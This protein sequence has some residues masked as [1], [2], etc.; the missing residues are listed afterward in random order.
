LWVL[1]IKRK[2][3]GGLYPSPN[4]KEKFMAPNFLSKFKIIRYLSDNIWPTKKIT[5]KQKLILA[6]LIKI[7]KKKIS[8]FGQKLQAKRALSVLYGN[9]SFKQYKTIKEKARALE[10]KISNNFI[11]LLEKRLDSV[12]YR[13]NICSTFQ[14]SKQLILHKKVFVNNRLIN[15]PSYSLEPGDVIAIAINNTQMFKSISI[16]SKKNFDEKKV[17]Q[18]KPLHLE[19]NYKTLHAIFLYPPQKLL[20]SYQLNINLLTQ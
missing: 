15:I 4:K 19:I 9:L 3:L 7:K 13:M 12:V 8:L 20:N 17:C 5:P 16:Q 14:S 11:T 10:G 18:T 6:S 2:T 1:S